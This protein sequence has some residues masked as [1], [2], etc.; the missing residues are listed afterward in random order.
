MG[1]HKHKFPQQLA[2]RFPRIVERIVT[3]WDSPEASSDYFQELL[4][5]DRLGRQGFPPEIASELFTLSHIY[6]AIHQSKQEPNDVW[7]NEGVEAKAELERR[8]V[9]ISDH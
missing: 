3:L 1:H 8:G 9:A 4:V 7:E 6:D 5:V 2:E